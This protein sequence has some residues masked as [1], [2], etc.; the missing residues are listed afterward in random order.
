[1]RKLLNEAQDTAQVGKIL[2]LNYKGKEEEVVSKIIELEE[3][4]LE[5]M[6]GIGVASKP[7]WLLQEGLVYVS[8]FLMKILSWNVRGL[9]RPEKMRK[10]KTLDRDR[11]IDVLLLQE[12]KRCSVDENFVKS[13]WPWEEI[14]FMEAGAEGSVGGMLCLWNLEIFLL[15]EYCSNRNF[16][17]LSSTSHH[18]FDCAIA[19]IYA[20][21]EVLKKRQL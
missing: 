19:N 9:R 10:I 8:S 2:G 14:D 15:K 21:N 20:P 13:L 12:T 4:D 17:M 18:S 1:M 11:K 16:I 3:N 6:K 5:R 7:I